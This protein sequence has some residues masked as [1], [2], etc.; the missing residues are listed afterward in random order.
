MEGKLDGLFQKIGI[1]GY[2][3]IYIHKEG[4][5]F[6]HYYLSFTSQNLSLLA[7]IFQGM[8]VFDAHVDINIAMNSVQCISVNIA[9]R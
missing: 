8:S 6:P 3:Y 9:V 7:S 4:K 5:L 1:E 2:I